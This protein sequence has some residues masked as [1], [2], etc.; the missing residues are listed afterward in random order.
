MN[1][2]QMLATKVTPLSAYEPSCQQR[3]RKVQR[4]K[5]RANYIKRAKVIE[6]YRAAWGDD[7]E[8][9]PTAVIEERLGRGPWGCYNTLR[10]WEG[11]NLLE[12]R[13]VLGSDGRPHRSLGV[14]WRWL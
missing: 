13:P 6:D 2:A 11:K 8:W 10:K 5:S 12:S 7:D 9:L 4:A 1:F 14:E 3:Q